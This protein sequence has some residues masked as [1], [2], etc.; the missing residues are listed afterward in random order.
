MAVLL[1]PPLILKDRVLVR[2]SILFTGAK[3][4]PHPPPYS[5]ESVIQVIMSDLKLMHSVAKLNS[6]LWECSIAHTQTV[7]HVVDGF[8]RRNFYYTNFFII[9][10]IS[11]F[12]ILPPLSLV[13]SKL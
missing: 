4:S 9:I 1:P 7:C 8:W 10:L 5:Y 6:I 13:Q 11:V 2:D 12:A 3:P